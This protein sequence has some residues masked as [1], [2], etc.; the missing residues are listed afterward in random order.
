MKQ[1]LI[2][3]ISIGFVATTFSQIQSSCEKPWVLQ[4]S[5]NYDVANMVVKHL[6]DIKSPDTS[7]IIIPQEYFDTVWNGLS[8][9]FNATSIPERDSVFDIFC[10]HQFLEFG[11][12]YVKAVHLS[13]DTSFQWTQNWLNGDTH[14]GY[15]ELDSFLERYGYWIDGTDF[16][17]GE[18]R[19][20]LL[21][22]QM[23]NPRAVA[24]SLETFE[25]I[26]WA[27]PDL[28]SSPG[29]E[30]NF[31]K[32][33][34]K[35]FYSFVLAW[36]DCMAGCA[37]KHRWNFKVD[38]TDCSVE[39]LGLITNKKGDFPNPIN[40][41]ISSSIKVNYEN[42]IIRSYPNPAKNKIT[43][44]YRLSNTST[45]ISAKLYNTNG[46]LVDELQMTG[47]K[48]EYNC[49]LLKPGVYF[50]SVLIE[51]KLQ[52]GKFIIAR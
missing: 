51:N 31:S 48:H 10:I 4:N 37:Y 5:Y 21:N 24:D 11:S 35:L 1:L 14:T 22:E 43:F 28:F 39:Y 19:A 13:I 12:P 33:G 2:F 40:C 26:L 44:E 3:L 29:N 25:G 16:H 27:V 34:N 15:E 45:T 38:H 50:Y 23:V 47:N 17:M 20:V 7:Q 6:Y 32:D 18:T 41:N 42:K 9:I 46:I 8:A 49:S 30:I 36:G 52:T